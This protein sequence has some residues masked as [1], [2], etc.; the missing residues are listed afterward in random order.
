MKKNCNIRYNF[1]HPETTYPN[2]EP[3]SGEGIYTFKTLKGTK[4]AAKMMKDAQGFYD[5][6]IF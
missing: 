3:E 1:K 6:E 2:F 5:I 4:E